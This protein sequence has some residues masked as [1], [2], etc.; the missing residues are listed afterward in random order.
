M[1][2]R[3]P[4]TAFYVIYGDEDFF[5]DRGLDWAKSWPNRSVTYLNASEK[6]DDHALLQELETQGVDEREITVIVDEAQKLKETKNKPLREHLENW[7]TRDT[8]VVLVG[9][10]RTEK[11]PEIW[12]LVGAKGKTILHKKFKPWPDKS[13]Q[14]E[15]HKWLEDEAKRIGLKLE[16]GVADLII[17]MTGQNLYRI[18]TE[19]K[20]LHT[21]LG[22]GGLVTKSY[23]SSV[24]AVTPSSEPRDVVEAT[25][26]KNLNGAMNHLSLTYKAMGDEAS[27]PIAYGL[28][29]EVSKTLTGKHMLGQGRSEE[30]IAAAL[31]MHPWRCKTFFLPMVSKHNI[32]DLV[33]YMK[34]LCKLDLDVKGPSRSK[35][36]LVELAVLSIAGK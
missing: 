23:L 31:G 33:R 4:Q 20:K 30:E 34:Q 10:C 35:R 28:M 7:S 6:L 9:I 29:R 18:Q 1:S 5:L 11:L 22:L 14:T 26:N 15:Y 17:Q 21:V 19:L 24:I 36:T 3:G 8:K 12:G 16:P 2:S 32:A 25:L 27:V 13:G